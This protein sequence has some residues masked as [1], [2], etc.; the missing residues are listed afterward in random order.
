MQR[1]QLSCPLV[2]LF[3]FFPCS[4]QEGGIILG[5]SSGVYPFDDIPA[6]ELGFEKLSRSSFLLFLFHL[7]KLDGV[8]F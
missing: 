1:H 7:R 5:G 3:K 4:F 8:R 2:H 6:A